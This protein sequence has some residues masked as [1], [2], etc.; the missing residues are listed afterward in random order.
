M[1]NTIFVISVATFLSGCIQPITEQNNYT[2]EKLDGY[3]VPVCV[4]RPVK[5]RQVNQAKYD[6]NTCGNW[7]MTEPAQYEV[8]NGECDKK[9]PEIVPYEYCLVNMPKKVFLVERTKEGVKECYDMNNKVELPILYCQ[10][11]M[12]SI[13]NV[14]TYTSVVQRTNVSQSMT[15]Y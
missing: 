4:N 14:N 8:L 13:Q 3:E 9:E 5:V 12:I 7:I 11:D 2:L 6:V 15:L 10:K 1:K